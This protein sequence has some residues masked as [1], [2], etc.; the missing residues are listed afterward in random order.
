MALAMSAAL[1]WLADSVRGRAGAWTDPGTRLRVLAIAAV[2]FVSNLSALAVDLRYP[3]SIAPSSHVFGDVACVIGAVGLLFRSKLAYMVAYIY[4]FVLGVSSASGIIWIPILAV[5]SGNVQAGSPFDGQLIQQIWMLLWVA[6]L[7]FG[8]WKYYWLYDRLRRFAERF[9]SPLY[10]AVMAGAAIILAWSIVNGIAP[11]LVGGWLAST[12]IDPY[13]RLALFA[14]VLLLVY[15]YTMWSYAT[16]R[17]RA[18]RDA[19]DLP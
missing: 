11:A 16:L 1:R 5:T 9:Q 4:T 17:S 15:A 12:A 7:V 3:A 14:A 19:F 8:V 18:V 6:L 2:V 13:L 10:G